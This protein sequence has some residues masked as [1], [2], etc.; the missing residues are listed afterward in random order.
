MW[1]KDGCKIIVFKS[2]DFLK[3][4]GIFILKWGSTADS[5]RWYFINKLIGAPFNLSVLVQL[6]LSARRNRKL[7]DNS[8]ATHFDSFWLQH[9][10]PF[11]FNKAK[12]K[13]ELIMLTKWLPFYFIYFSSP[14]ARRTLSYLDYCYNI[15]YQAFKPWTWELNF[16]GIRAV[17]VSERVP[18]VQ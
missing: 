17:F 1:I 18:Y 10:Y 11:F 15:W 7:V 16:T 12:S 8:L 4:Y 9:K 3:Y 13:F 2:W 5:S 14:G 6:W